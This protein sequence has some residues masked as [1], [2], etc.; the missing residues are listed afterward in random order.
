MSV[1]ELQSIGSGDDRSRQSSLASLA[2]DL[3]KRSSVGHRLGFG[4]DRALAHLHGKLDGDG[5]P[6][7]AS[8]T[9][10]GNE[11]GGSQFLSTAAATASGAASGFGSFRVPFQKENDSADRKLSSLA[12]GAGDAEDDHRQQGQPLAA[13]AVSDAPILQVGVMIAL[14]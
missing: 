12:E 5:V 7:A 8:P 2:D 3:T 11:S 6:T 4:L 1:E 13:A 14:T 10:A 9:A